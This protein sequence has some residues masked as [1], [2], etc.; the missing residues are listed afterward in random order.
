MEDCKCD[1]CGYFEHSFADEWMWD[2]THHWHDS[3]CTHKNEKDEYEG[4]NLVSGKCSDCGY[5]DP[6]KAPVELPMIPA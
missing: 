2:E 3:T 5:V 1:V 6:T 4:H